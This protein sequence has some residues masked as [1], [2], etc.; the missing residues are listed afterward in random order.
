MK[1]FKEIMSWVIPI[2]VGLLIALLIKSYWFTLVK[3][4]GTSM[5]PNLVNNEQVF[6]FRPET[7]HRGS[8]I[9]FDAK[10]EDPSVTESKD[11]V[12]RV[13]A[14][15]GDT[16]SAKD[17][18][19]K[20]NDKV[21]D[22]S[23]IPAS[24]QK[25]TNTVNNVG[26]FDSLAELGTHMGWQKNAKAIKV[27]A[28]KYFVLGDHRSVSNDSRYWGFVSAKKVLGVVKAGFWVKAETKDN[29]NTQWKHYF[30]TDNK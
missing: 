21:V 1:A 2:L 29:I 22:Q 14:I 25:D 26:N 13:I 10:G 20:V 15:P 17:G 12:K 6:V 18:V 30:A 19:I 9:V 24:Q 5:Q 16:V 8:V 11:Y 7:V 3:V 23:Y 27:P 28:G 4:D